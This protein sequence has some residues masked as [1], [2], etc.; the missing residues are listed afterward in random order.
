MSFLLR[1]EEEKRV[2]SYSGRGES[3]ILAQTGDSTWFK[4][5]AVTRSSSAIKTTSSCTLD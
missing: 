3:R 1:R 4:F 5:L 2:T